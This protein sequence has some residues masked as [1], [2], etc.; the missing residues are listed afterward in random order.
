MVIIS[1]DGSSCKEP[2]GKK[3]YTPEEFKA[4]RE[5]ILKEMEQN[6]GG[7]NRRIIRMN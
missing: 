7:G 4:E 3:R 1:G 6:N 2:S 5:K